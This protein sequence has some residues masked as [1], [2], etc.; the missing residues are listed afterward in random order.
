MNDLSISATSAA[1]RGVFWVI[2]GRLFPFPF[3]EN[4]Q[5][6]VAKSG[7]TYNHKAL[8]AEIRKG[9]TP[10]N[11]YPRGRVVITNRGI[12]VI[13]LNP[14]I[15]DPKIIAE[16]KTAFGIAGNDFKVIEDHSNHYKCFLDDG[17]Q[18]DN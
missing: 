17:W 2:D 15:N 4:D 8:W 10:F 5:V 11:Y 3:K 18:S 13:Y 14:K 1:T 6:G 16:V 7:L 9:S 12:P